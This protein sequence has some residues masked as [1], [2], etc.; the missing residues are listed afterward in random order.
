MLDVEIVPLR[1]DGLDKTL[2]PTHKWDPL[3]LCRIIQPFMI[4]TIQE[5]STRSSFNEV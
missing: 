5:V 4:G 1:I 2:V 3:M